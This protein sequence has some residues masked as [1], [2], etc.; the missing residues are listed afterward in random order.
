MNISLGEFERRHGV[1]KGT[2]SRKAREL[3]FDT[4]AGLVPD[5][6]T[7]LKVEF[8]VEP[9]PEPVAAIA[10]ATPTKMVINTGNHRGQME[11]PKVPE[12]ADLGFVRGDEA[13]LSSF[14]PEDIERFLGACDGFLD[15]VDQDYQHQLSVTQRKEQGVAKVRAK[16]EKVKEAKLKYQMRSE[17]IALHNRGLDAELQTGMAELGKLSA[18]D[19]GDTAA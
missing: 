15:A 10:P 4:S 12:S 2:A 14:D 16:V 8:K 13:P 1:N 6:Y 19:G 3:G 7:A 17:A 9:T 5:A 18:T 11:L